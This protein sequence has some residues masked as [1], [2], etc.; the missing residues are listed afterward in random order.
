MGLQGDGRGQ[1]GKRA[2]ALTEAGSGLRIMGY[3]IGPLDEIGIVATKH[4]PP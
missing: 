1:A 3:V 2:S 4:G